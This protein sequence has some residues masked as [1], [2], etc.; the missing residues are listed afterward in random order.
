[1]PV[2]KARAAVVV[3]HDREVLAQSGEPRHPDRTCPV[4]LEIREPRGNT[5]QRW[6]VTVASPRDAG[7]VSAPDEAHLLA[8]GLNRMAF[9]LSQQAKETARRG[10]PPRRGFRPPTG[11]RH[12]T[13]GS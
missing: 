2:R 6:S 4:T 8:H 3:A 11:C 10:T 5:H 9:R 13:Q 1:M 12:R 7:S